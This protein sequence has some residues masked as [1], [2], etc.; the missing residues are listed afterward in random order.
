MKKI[1]FVALFALLAM[2]GAKA[3]PRDDALSAMLRCSGIADRAQRLACYDSASARAPGALNNAAPSP[4]PVMASAVPPPA[5]AIAPRRKRSTSFMDKLFGGGGPKR[6]PQTTV[7]QFGSE[8]IAN[9][10]THAY[11]I[12]MD[13]DR[14]DQISAR[15]VSYQFNQ[16]YV[17]VSLD[18]GQ[19]WQ[20]TADGNPLGRLS[21][22]ALAYSAVISRGGA[23]SYDMKLN[24]VARTLL[25]RRIQ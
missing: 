25:V 9:G 7:A 1:G 18:N 10:G 4:A 15:V 5:P 19:V 16:G 12:A 8:S 22:P 13:G 24:D 14:I 2:T 21:R 6:A 23:G 17:V 3:D 11:P 20:Q